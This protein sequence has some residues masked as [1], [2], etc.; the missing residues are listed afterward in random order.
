MF[1]TNPETTMTA[2]LTLAPTAIPLRDGRVVYL[3]AGAFPA[4][5]PELVAEAAKGQ[6]E[7]RRAAFAY[8]R[9]AMVADADGV[10]LHLS[11]FAAMRWLVSG[12]TDAGPE[13]NEANANVDGYLRA[14]VVFDN[15]A[16]YAPERTE[17][18]C[19]TCGKRGIGTLYLAPD[20]MLTPSE[21]LFVGDC[22]K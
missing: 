17:R 13:I 22:C 14:R 15:P 9:A 4:P 7:A 21:V 1:N 16:D 11:T 12:R 19:D 6:R 5:A 8:S 3:P 2:E 20:A 18:C 10:E